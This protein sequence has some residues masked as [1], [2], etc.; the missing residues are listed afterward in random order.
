[1]TIRL[2]HWNVL[3]SNA[4]RNDQFRSPK[5]AILG[6][7]TA[8][9]ASRYGLFQKSSKACWAGYVECVICRMGCFCLFALRLSFCL[10]SSFGFAESAFCPFG[11]I[12]LLVVNNLHLAWR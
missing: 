2:A 6:R 4:L 1:M 8:H 3:I 5:Q 10:D 7:K 12:C 11:S 9:I